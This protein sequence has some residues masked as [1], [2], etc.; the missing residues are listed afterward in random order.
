MVKAVKKK[1]VTMN[2]MHARMMMMMMM[3]KKDKKIR[4]KKLWRVDG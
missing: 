3:K 4:A 2:G 1:D